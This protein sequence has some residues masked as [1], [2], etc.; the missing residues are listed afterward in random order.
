MGRLSWTI[1]CNVSTRVDPRKRQGG[2]SQRRSREKGSRGWSDVRPVR[3]EMQV[4]SQSW[5]R[6]RNTLSPGASRR[7]SSADTVILVQ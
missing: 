5:K 4:I 7:N 6:Q 1:I 3:Q 2:Q